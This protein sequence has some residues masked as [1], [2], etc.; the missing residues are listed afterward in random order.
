[1]KIPEKIQTKNVAIYKG[2]SLDS[3]GEDKITVNGQEYKGE[4]VIGYLIIS[5]GIDT[6]IVSEHAADAALLRPYSINVAV[7][8]V[9][10]E[11]VCMDTGLS[12]VDGEKLYEHDLVDCNLTDFKSSLKKCEIIWDE[13]KRRFAIKS[14]INLYPM[15]SFYKYKKVI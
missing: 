8:Y 2:F 7:K 15:K 11:T 12:D 9:L 5:K 4:W 10:P 6:M 13:E 14:G 1:M 3:F